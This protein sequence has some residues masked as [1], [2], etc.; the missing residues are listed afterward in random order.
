MLFLSLSTL[1]IP[2]KFLLQLRNFY[3][4]I[5]KNYEIFTDFLLCCCLQRLIHLDKKLKP[6]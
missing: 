4:F 6:F 2:V 5:H 1:F 3:S